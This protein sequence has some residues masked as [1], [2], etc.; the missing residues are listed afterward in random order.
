MTASDYKYSV[1]IEYIIYMTLQCSNAY[2]VVSTN[3]SLPSTYKDECT[4]S[5]GKNFSMKVMVCADNYIRLKGMYPE[6]L[7]RDHTYTQLHTCTDTY[8]HTHIHTCPVLSFHCTFGSHVLPFGDGVRLALR[9]Y[10]MHFLVY[11]KATSTFEPVA[12]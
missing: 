11:S 12:T 6:T 4:L 3:P 9:D 1:L 7:L 10:S 2:S 8:I 5:A